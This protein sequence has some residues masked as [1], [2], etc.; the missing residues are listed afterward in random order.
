[1]N[2]RSFLI[3]ASAPIVAVPASALVGLGGVAS[4]LPGISVCMAPESAAVAPPDPKALMLRYITFLAHEHRA[5][6]VEFHTRPGDSEE[7][8]AH[9][10]KIPPMFWFPDDRGVTA[11]V[12]AAPPSARAARVLMGAGL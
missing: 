4:P 8:L 5:A 3:A 6:L 2:R 7:D 11:L 10:A 9:Y 12:Q 1:M